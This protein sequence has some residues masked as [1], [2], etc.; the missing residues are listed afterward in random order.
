MAKAMTAAERKAMIADSLDP[1]AEPIDLPESAHVPDPVVVPPVVSAAVPPLGGD[2]AGLIAALVAALQQS[3]AGTADAIREGLTANAAMARNPIAETYLNG[4][5]PAKSVFSHK[6]GDLAHPRTKLRCPMFL[7]V[8]TEHGQVVPAF[9]IYEDVCTEQ[10][11]VLCNDLQPGSFDVERN[12]GQSAKWQIVEQKDAHGEITR[13][14]IA[15]PQMWLSKD[16][17]A[18][19]PPMLRVNRKGETTAGFLKQLVEAASAA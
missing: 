16:Q 15:V 3:N 9:E 19:M 14:V 4:G 18:Q 7:G 8:Y 2:A 12:D 17:Q 13:L 10:E 11:R 1:D 5:Y 6:D